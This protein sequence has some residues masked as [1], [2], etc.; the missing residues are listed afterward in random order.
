MICDLPFLFSLLCFVMFIPFF[1]LLFE[2]PAPCIF[3]EYDA[4]LQIY[5]DQIV[6]LFDLK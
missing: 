1:I 6:A 2:V 5:R 4:K 3:P